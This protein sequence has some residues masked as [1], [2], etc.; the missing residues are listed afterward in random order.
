M[1]DLQDPPQPSPGLC[2]PMNHEC[3]TTQSCRDLGKANHSCEAV[4][5]RSHAIRQCVAQTTTLPPGA[6]METNCTFAPMANSDHDFAVTYNI[7][8]EWTY[9]CNPGFHLDGRENSITSQSNFC[10]E[11]SRYDREG[12]SA[13]CVQNDV[14]CNAEYTSC[15]VDAELEETRVYA[16]CQTFQNDVFFDISRSD[17]ERDNYCTMEGITARTLA[18][19]VCSSELNSC[20][21]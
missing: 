14:N 1:C 4:G 16:A 7:G 6:G 9:T 8:D 13:S 12:G 10:V 18:Y 19:I 3:T 17:K 5:R 11:G 2:T 20:R 15:R 21:G